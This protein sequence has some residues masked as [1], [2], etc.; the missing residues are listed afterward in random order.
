MKK[1]YKNCYVM[2]K[3]TGMTYQ[4]LS[5]E[6]TTHGRRWVRTSRKGNT[7]GN[8]SCSRCQVCETQ[9]IPLNYI[10]GVLAWQAENIIRRKQSRSMRDLTILDLHKQ[11]L[12]A[13]GLSRG[14]VESHFSGAC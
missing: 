14:I 10:E 4:L 3:R 1:L 11:M 8:K 13:K 12:E 9:L 2:D 6:A 5:S 7:F